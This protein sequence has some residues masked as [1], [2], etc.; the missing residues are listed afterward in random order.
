MRRDCT[1]VDVSWDIKLFEAIEL[2]LEDSLEM[3][4]QSV[5]TIGERIATVDGDASLDTTYFSQ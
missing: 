3:S 1:T 2:Y 4:G 5:A